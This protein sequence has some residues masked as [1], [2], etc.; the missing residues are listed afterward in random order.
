LLPEKENKMDA[1]GS[2][3]ATPRAEQLL[4]IKAA[5]Q[6]IGAKE[7][8][9]RRAVKCGIIPCYT[10]FNTRRLVRLSEVIAAIDASQAKGGA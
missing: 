10:P 2:E 8:Q 5:A 4:T 6:A 1:N 3:P 9:L 7:W